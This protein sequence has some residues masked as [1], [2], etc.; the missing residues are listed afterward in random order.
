M[1]TCQHPSHE[2][3]PTVGNC[4]DNFRMMKENKRMVENRKEEDEVEKRD[5]KTNK[6]QREDEDR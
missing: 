6:W 4:N 1:L 3:S 5:K 2:A